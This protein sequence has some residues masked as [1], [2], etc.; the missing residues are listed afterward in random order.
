[1]ADAEAAI[2]SHPNNR[3]YHVSCILAAVIRLGGE[4]C[5]QL[6][7]S[8]ASTGHGYVD[9]EWQTWGKGKCH[10]MLKY[11]I[12]TFPYYSYMLFI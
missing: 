1:M 10:N 4:A 8:F 9:K 5:E 7:K 3:R 2:I 11:V 12:I 6:T